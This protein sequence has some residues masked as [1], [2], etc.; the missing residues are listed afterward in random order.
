MSL[1]MIDLLQMRMTTH[2]PQALLLFYFGFGFATSRT[3]GLMSVHKHWYLDVRPHA[4]L[5]F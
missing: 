3:L 1:G 4:I 5:F 2:G